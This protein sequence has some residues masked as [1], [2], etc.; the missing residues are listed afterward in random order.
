MSSSPE[1]LPVTECMELAKEFP[2]EA[3]DQAAFR[4]ANREVRGAHGAAPGQEAAVR[5]AALIT[6]KNHER[7]LY[8]D[9][10]ARSR[11]L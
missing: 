1:L 2:S 10:V 4:A 7:M 11:N 6:Q 8:N 5:P 3:V 9:C